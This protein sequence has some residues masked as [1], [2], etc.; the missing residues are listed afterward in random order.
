MCNQTVNPTVVSTADNQLQAEFHF[1]CPIYF[2]DKPEFLPMVRPVSEESLTK[3]RGQ[4]DL[5][6]IYPLYMSDN[7]MDDERI[8]P[9]AEF[10]G[11][12]AWN[13]IG[14]AHV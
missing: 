10:V 12:T 13:K 1:P 3:R 11:G 4:H 6:E 9:F 5:S 7:F 14:R 8:R 2:I